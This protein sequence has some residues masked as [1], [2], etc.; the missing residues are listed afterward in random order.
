MEYWVT[1]DFNLIATRE[2]MQVS[3]SLI[4]KSIGREHDGIVLQHGNTSTPKGQTPVIRGFCPKSDQFPLKLWGV[5]L[6]C[7]R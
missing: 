1:R 5:R 3:D 7:L 4:T 6:K 2:S